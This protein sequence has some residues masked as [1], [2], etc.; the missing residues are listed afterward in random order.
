MSTTVSE[1]VRE[2]DEV[3]LGQLFTQ[4]HTANSFDETPVS[5]EVLERLHEL[6]VMPP[7]AMN[8]QPLRILW[9]RS[10]EAQATLGALMGEGNRDKTL[11][12][13]LVAVLA[14][15][16]Q[17]HEHLELLAPFR[18]AAKDTFA[19]NEPMRVGMA[20][21]NAAI[22]MGYFLLAARSLGLDVGP[23]AG[24]DAQGVD[25]AFFADNGWQ[26]FAVVNLGYPAAD[27]A[28]Y[29]ERQGRLEFGEQT[30]TV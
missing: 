10:P 15:D 11:A 16:A 24:F 5:D 6:T 22:Q 19:A 17:W 30:L 20:K 8:I 13:P 25:A 29:R 23:Q 4:A 21:T 1:P 27:G 12:A 7:S 2:L 18:A 3:A 9:V 14:F 28:G 26:S